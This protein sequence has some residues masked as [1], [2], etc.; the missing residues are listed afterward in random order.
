[1]P[2]IAKTRVRNDLF[3]A[4][5]GLDRGRPK[6]VEALWYLVKCALF[7]TPLPFPS[8]LKCQVLRLFG[9]K[10]GKGVV[11]KPR[12]NVHF[13]WKLWVGDYTWIGEEVFILNFEP[14]T[15]GAQ[16]CLS[17]R[18][19]L[20]AGNHDYRS[21][22]MPYR[23]R[24]IFIE[25]GAW[26][27]AQSFVAPEVTIG[28]E[29]VIGAGSVVTRNQPPQMVCAGN[30]CVPVKNRWHPVNDDYFS[31]LATTVISHVASSY[32]T[33]TNSAVAAAAT[34]VDIA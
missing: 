28:S 24:P 1:V 4:R 34:P 30:P 13:P 16:C 2:N 7:L 29:A 14:V 9:A 20:C 31:P 22:T 6:L 11:I 10:V 32:P 19:F 12:V 5:N 21:P 17:Q 25:D 18:V 8:S 15:I 23:N 27:G 33:G 3:D 26:V